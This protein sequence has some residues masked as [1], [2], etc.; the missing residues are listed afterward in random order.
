[1]YRLDHVTFAILKLIGCREIA[2]RLGLEDDVNEY[3]E[4]IG[5]AKELVKTLF[6]NEERHT[7][8][9]VDTATEK[10]CDEAIGYECFFPYMYHLFEGDAE[11]FDHFGTDGLECDFSLTSVE[12]SCP[13]FWSDNCLTGP[14]K[15]TPAE[16]HLY[17]C[18]WNGPLWPYAISGALEGFGAVGEKDTSVR[19]KWL[20][21]FTKYNELHF[22]H[23]DRSL[24]ALT[25]HYNTTDATSFRGHIDYFHSCWLE[26]FYSFY[27][28]IKLMPDGTVEFEP[29]TNAEFEIKGLY[30]GPDGYDFSQ[31]YENGQLVR[32]VKKIC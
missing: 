25:E 14:T 20:D 8:V 32:K 16:P 24:P 3:T 13:M 30:F 4:M 10:Q 29:F 5:R 12:K 9:D 2:G 26:L 31:K 17:D 1:M 11:V 28:G 19:E 27:A 18:C 21:L 22:L 6:W 15:A 7:F 23:G